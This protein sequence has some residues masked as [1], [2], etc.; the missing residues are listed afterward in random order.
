MNGEE[1]NHSISTTQ[2]LAKWGNSVDITHRWLGKLPPKLDV[3]L[4][5]VI[6]KK[7]LVKF[8]YV[9]IILPEIT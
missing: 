7:V 6:Q 3:L 4:L 5:I 9:I 2:I 8:S 1:K